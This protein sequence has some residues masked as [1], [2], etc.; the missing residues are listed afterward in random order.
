M[1]ARAREK[2]PGTWLAAL[3][4]ITLSRY[5]T[6]VTVPWKPGIHPE[7][8]TELGSRTNSLVD[9][10]Q[11]SLIDFCEVGYSKAPN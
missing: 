2:S 4:K 7:E 9:V 10:P 11:N 1:S 3:T 5:D 6:S 8:G